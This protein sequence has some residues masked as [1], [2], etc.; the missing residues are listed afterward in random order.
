MFTF[1]DVINDF[2]P[3]FEKWFPGNQSSR[4]IDSIL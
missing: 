3:D 4:F 2:Y 1:C